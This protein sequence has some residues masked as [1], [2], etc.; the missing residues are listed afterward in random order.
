MASI[1]INL[2]FDIPISSFYLDKVYGRLRV[3]CTYGKTESVPLHRSQFRPQ[4]CE[5]DREVFSKSLGNI[6]LDTLSFY[7]NSFPRN[8]IVN[9]IYAGDFQ[10]ERVR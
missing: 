4:T 1:R 8:Y 3:T 7:C 2:E 6:S 10:L 9:L 5:P